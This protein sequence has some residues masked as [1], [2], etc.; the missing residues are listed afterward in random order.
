MAKTSSGSFAQQNFEVIIEKIQKNTPPKFSRTIEPLYK[1]V[2]IK[3][4]DG[5][6]EGDPDVTYT[7][8]K[9]IDD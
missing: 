4:V 6:I 5:E 8:P 3:G 9:A 1:V 2:L 7:S